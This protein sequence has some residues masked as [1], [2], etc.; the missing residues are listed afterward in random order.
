MLLIF[1]ILAGWSAGS[2]VLGLVVAKCLRFGMKGHR[3]H[4]FNADELQECLTVNVT[5]RPS[6]SNRPPSRLAS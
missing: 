5:V 6:G 1:W 2:V 4:S 3:Q